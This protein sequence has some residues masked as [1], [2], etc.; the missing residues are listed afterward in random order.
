MPKY[1]SGRRDVYMDVVER[2]ERYIRL[3]ILVNGDK[4]PSVRAVAEDMGIN[5]NTVQKAYVYLES[6]NLLRAVPKKGVYV[7]YGE[8]KSTNDVYEAVYTIRKSGVDKKVLL[9]VVE[10]VY[11]DAL[12]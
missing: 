4:L 7:I 5:P 2:F 3:G 8:E 9:E 6:K 12:Y 10:E 11:K 1:L